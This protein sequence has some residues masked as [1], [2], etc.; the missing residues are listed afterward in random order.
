MAVE[1]N[2]VELLHKEKIAA[3]NNNNNNNEVYH[4][5]VVQKKKISSLRR[6]TPQVKICE[7][8]TSKMYEIYVQNSLLKAFSLNE[9]SF[10]QILFLGYCCSDQKFNYREQKSVRWI[11]DTGHCLI[12]WHCH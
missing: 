6:L 2:T 3:N 11:I 4:E 5:T 7:Q 1:E 12:S 9:C 8:N 10:V